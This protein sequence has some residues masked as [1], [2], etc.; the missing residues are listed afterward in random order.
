MPNLLTQHSS[1]ERLRSLLET[2]PGVRRAFVDSAENRIY[3]ICD[4]HDADLALEAMVE[5]VLTR[6]GIAPGTVAIDVSYAAPAVTP[7]R[8]RFVEMQLDHPRIDST[9]GTAVLDWAGEHFHGTAEG[10]SGA[11]SEIRTCAQA[12]VHALAAVVGGRVPLDLLGVKAIRIFDQDLISVILRSADA[13]DRRLVGVSLVL[14]DVHT[15]A[16]IAVLH[17]TNRLLGNHLE[18]PL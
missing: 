16:A 18:I 17:A 1:P 13:P 3:L 12:T 2:V 7:R 8:V 14:Q 9:V 11:A 5:A 6:S 4:V 15:S 10:G